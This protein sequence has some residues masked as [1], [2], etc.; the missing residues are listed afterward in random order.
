MKYLAVLFSLFMI[1]CST[2]TEVL[3]DKVYIP[4]KCKVPE[5]AVPTNQATDETDFKNIYLNNKNILIYTEVIK[6]DL[7]TCTTGTF[8]TQGDTK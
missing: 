1:G 8:K 7:T 2:K 6:S 5:T 3:P 4:V